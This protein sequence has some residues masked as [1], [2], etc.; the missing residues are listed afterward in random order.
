MFQFFENLYQPFSSHLT[1]FFFPLLSILY[2]ISEFA[3]KGGDCQ[4]HMEIQLFTLMVNPAPDSNE[5]Q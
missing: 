5:L 3:Q 1:A 2:L 4:P